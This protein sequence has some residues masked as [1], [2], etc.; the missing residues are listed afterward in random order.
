MG[1]A[2]TGLSLTRLA[3]AL[4]VRSLDASPNRG[5]GLRTRTRLKCRPRWGILPVGAGSAMRISGEGDHEIPPRGDTRNFQEKV[6]PLFLPGDAC[7]GGWPLE[8]DAAP[9]VDAN[10]ATEQCLLHDYPPQPCIDGHEPVVR[11]IRPAKHVVAL[12]RFPLV[13]RPVCFSPGLASGFPSRWPDYPPS[14]QEHPRNAADRRCMFLLLQD[15]ALAPPPPPLLPFPSCHISCPASLGHDLKIGL[16][17][18][19]LVGASTH[20]G[21]QAPRCP[22]LP[23]AGRGAG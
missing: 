23:A 6:P 17:D 5:D 14:G 16:V 7:K 19:H 11:I 10:D 1:Q 18:Q 12:A 9:H 22:P 21:D 13:A 3:A 4:L 8:E 2:I 15:R 20:H